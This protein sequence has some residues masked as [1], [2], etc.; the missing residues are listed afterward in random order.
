MPSTGFFPS[1]R[2]EDHFMIVKPTA[3]DLTT[4]KSRPIKFI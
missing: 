2:I 3:S 1:V 4:Y